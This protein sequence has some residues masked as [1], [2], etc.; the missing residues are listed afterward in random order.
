MKKGVYLIYMIVGFGFMAFV[1]IHNFSTFS[2]GSAGENYSTYVKATAVV[3]ELVTTAAAVRRRSAMMTAVVTFK[4]AEGQ[5]VEAVAMILRI[6]IYGL[7]ADK[8]DTLTVFYNPQKPAFI[9]T[10]ADKYNVIGGNL[11]FVYA[12]III[13][14][15]III[16][17]VRISRAKM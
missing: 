16:A 1:L 12:G 14:V 11:L 8:G 17:F 13:G 3:K 9:K 2:G 4:T 7:I 5:T 10:Y 6:P 15:C